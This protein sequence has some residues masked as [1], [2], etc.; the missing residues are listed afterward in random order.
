MDPTDESDLAKCV[1]TYVLVKPQPSEVAWGAYLAQR[2]ATATREE[3]AP[4]DSPVY[5]AAAFSVAIV[6]DGIVLQEEEE[7]AIRTGTYIVSQNVV[8]DGDTSIRS[9]DV[10]SRI[11]S[12]TNPAA[13]DV[14]IEYHHRTRY[15]SVEFICN[16]YYRAHNPL[17]GVEL[18]TREP[19]GT[20]KMHGF[21]PLLLMAGKKRTF[22]ISAAQVRTLHRVLFGKASAKNPTLANKIGARDMLRLLLASVGISLSLPTNARGDRVERGQEMEWAGLEDDGRWLGKNIRRLAAEF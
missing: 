14:Y 19:E 18:D 22:N 12:P 1:A 11:Y 3:D 13:V 20:R 8:E 10:L 15:S 17:S 9:A 2:D 16:I 21:R 6:L 7:D 5:F 4:H